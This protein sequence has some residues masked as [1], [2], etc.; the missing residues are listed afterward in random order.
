VE[1]KNFLQHYEQI[2]RRDV[3][4]GILKSTIDKQISTH[5]SD[6]FVKIIMGYLATNHLIHQTLTTEIS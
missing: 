2:E 3:R 5:G 1:I 4:L 6:G